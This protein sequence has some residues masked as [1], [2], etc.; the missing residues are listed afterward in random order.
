[1]DKG[2]VLNRQ[3]KVIT[4]LYLFGI[5]DRFFMEKWRL[6]LVGDGILRIFMV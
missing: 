4:S 5:V 6:G 3:F 2:G 1:L